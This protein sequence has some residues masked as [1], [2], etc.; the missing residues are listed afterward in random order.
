MTLLQI[1]KRTMTIAGTV[2][3]V[4]LLFHMLSNLSFFFGDSFNQF[5]QIYNSA[6]IRW[7]VLVIVLIC[8]WIHVRAAVNIRR[9]N[10]Q[11]RQVG[12]KKHEKFHIPAALVTLSIILLFLFIVIHI[13]QSLYVNPDDVR[14]SV[15]SWFSSVIITLFYLT[16]V[17]I[18]VMHL[19]HSLINVL[20]TLGISAK[21]HH[22]AIH[23]IVA[24]LG[25]GFVSIPVYVW[26]MS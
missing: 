21:M 18:L 5:Y 2:L 19:Q 9:K 25:V 26:L 22:I 10:S 8:L 15:M 17:F 3:S 20:Q 13:I 7:P 6:W 24:L 14:S 4:Y 11:A 1:Q 12:Y 16:G 23:S